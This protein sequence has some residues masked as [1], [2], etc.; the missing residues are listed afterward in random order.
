[1][2]SDNAATNGVIHVI[3][4]V[5]IPLPIRQNCFPFCDGLLYSAVWEQIKKYLVLISNEP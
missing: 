4:K 1:M 3:N 5:K 2:D